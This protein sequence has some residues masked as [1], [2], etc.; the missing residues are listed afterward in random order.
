MALAGPSFARRLQPG[1]NKDAAGRGDVFK[2]QRAR[3]GC[4]DVGILGDW[5]K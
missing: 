4:E 5:G 1:L 2:R 3:P